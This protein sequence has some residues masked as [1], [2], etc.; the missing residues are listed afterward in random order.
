MISIFEMKK[1]YIF[2]IIFTM[3]FKG[4][5]EY[6]Y[7]V[8]VHPLF[9]YSGFTLDVSVA[10]MIESYVIV[11]IVSYLLAILDD[12][13]KPSKIVVYILFLNLYLPISSLYWL[14]N[15]SR[16]YY[17]VISLAFLL[18][19]FII[20]KSKPIAIFRLKEG[21]NLALIILAAITV[22]VYGYLIATGGLQR[23]NL[24]LLNV[25]STREGYAESSNTLIAYLLP[26]Q[27]HVVNLSLLTFGLIKNNKYIVFAMLFLQ[28]FMFSMTNFKSFL[29]APVV[30]VGLFFIIKQGYKN[31]LLFLMSFL[32]SFLMVVMLILYKINGGIV[33]LSIF[34][35]RLFFA[36]ADLH[37]IFYEYFAQIDKY[38]L[39]HSI[40]SSVFNNPYGVSPVVLVAKNVYETD[41]SPNVGIFGDAFLN[42]GLIGIL[43]FSAI[44]GLVLVFFDSVAKL[45]P[46]ILP[47]SIIAIPSMSLVNSAMFT[48]FATHGILFAIFVTWLTSSLFKERERNI[49]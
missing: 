46:F 8:F 42:F 35:R 11:L 12:Y 41:F 10:K 29:F 13:D 6:G 17:L 16:E 43:I 2:T 28:V 44:L 7:F 22:V 47:I 38:K 48:S 1:K 31:C 3:V 33:L 45:A 21:S 18:M 15:N 40:L 39:S 4:L 19:Y 23:M 9:E 5:L 24:N 32:L 14:Q 27:A 36:P 26:W 49:N 37:F 34:L 20:S 25:Y 30:V